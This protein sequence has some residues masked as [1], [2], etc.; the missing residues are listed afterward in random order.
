M[1]HLPLMILPMYLNDRCSVFVILLISVSEFISN[2]VLLSNTK[3]GD[4][5][6]ILGFFLRVLG[7]T[8]DLSWSVGSLSADL[9]NVLNILVSS[10]NIVIGLV[11]FVSDCNARTKKECDNLFHI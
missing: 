5:S 6:F 10:R 4:V 3:R 9:E 2:H 7:K 11:I 1:V 8:E